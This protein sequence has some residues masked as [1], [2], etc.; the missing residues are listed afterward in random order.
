M[1][2]TPLVRRWR[3]GPR[4]TQHRPHHLPRH[5]PRH[6]RVVRAARWLRPAQ[7]RII[8]LLG[9]HADDEAPTRP[10]AWPR[11]SEPS[12]RSA[13]LR[14]PRCVPDGESFW[15]GKT[16]ARRVQRLPG[17]WQA[18]ST[19]R[20]AWSVPSIRGTV[21]PQ[22]HRA[23]PQLA[24]RGR[25]RPGGRCGHR[26][27]ARRRTARPGGSSA[28]SRT[29]DLAELRSASVELV[30]AFE[31]CFPPLKARWRPVVDGRSRVELCGGRIVLA[32]RPDLTLGQAL[33]RGQGHHRPQDRASAAATTSTTSA[34][35]P[36]VDTLQRRAAAAPAGHRLPRRRPTRRSR[37]SPSA[38]S[39]PPPSGWSAPVTAMVETRWGTLPTRLQAG[40]HCVV[41]PGRDTCAARASSAAAPTTADGGSPTTVTGV[42]QRTSIACGSASISSNRPAPPQ[43]QPDQ[44]PAGRPASGGHRPHAHQSATAPCTSEPSG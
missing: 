6:A 21:E 22:G 34:S 42:G 3:H 18:S 13:S 29:V 31:E 38:C 23:A 17:R 33:R 43:S 8:E 9:R 41:V 27:D 40:R 32:G 7:Q 37:P 25:T 24:G 2:V 16:P 36:C 35:T 1:S 10:R 12:S 11:G 20:S 44:Q 5:V 30:T 26:P 39:R 28:R 4:C 15:V 19:P 14:R